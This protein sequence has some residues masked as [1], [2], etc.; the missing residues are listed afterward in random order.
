MKQIYRLVLL[1][2]SFWGFS[3]VNMTGSEES[4]KPGFNSVVSSPEEIV[5]SSA[6]SS[7]STTPGE[8]GNSTVPTNPSTGVDSSGE[9]LSSQVGTSSAIQSSSSVAMVPDYCQENIWVKEG[10]AG[11]NGKGTDYCAP[12]KVYHNENIW[13]AKWCNATEPSDEALEWKFVKPCAN[14]GSLVPGSSPA[15]N[16][17]ATGSSS[18]SYDPNDPDKLGGWFDQDTYEK[19]VPNRNSFYTWN[20][21]KGAFN[22]VAALKNSSSGDSYGKFL[23]EGTMDQKKREAAAFFAHVAKETGLG[24]ALSGLFHIHESCAKP[25]TGN[26]LGYKSAGS[27]PLAS[28]KYYY[29]RGPMQLSWNSN[30][31]WFSETYFGDKMKLINDPDLLERDAEVAFAAAIW[32][33]SRQENWGSMPPSIHDILVNNAPYEGLTGFGATI[34]AINGAIECPTSQLAVLRGK[35]YK[36]LQE[37]LG[38]QIETTNLT[39]S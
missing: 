20:A 15:A 29:G 34:K 37:V 11:F 5:S 27:W 25:P 6:L 3:C 9:N 1:A 23:T 16:S 26:C 36:S 35:Y 4:E 30:Y 33:W 19:L 17:S 14:G 22:K 12:E 32:F 31:G 10:G 28:G 38:V 24:S 21:F 13:E 7:G 39:C 18:D 2:M 8:P